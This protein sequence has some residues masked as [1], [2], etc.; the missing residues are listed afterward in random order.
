MSPPLILNYA[1]CDLMVDTLREAI[2]E[3]E[4]ELRREGYVR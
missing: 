2:T 3:V 1:Q 4:R